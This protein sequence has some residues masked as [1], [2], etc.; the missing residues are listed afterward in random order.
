M[1]VS[2]LVVSNGALLLIIY[3]IPIIVIAPSVL[4]QACIT[5]VYSVK[6]GTLRITPVISEAVSYNDISRICQFH[7]YQ[8]TIYERGLKVVVNP[9]KYLHQAW[10]QHPFDQSNILGSA[11]LDITGKKLFDTF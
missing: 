5:Y 10:S 3:V 4:F 8:F 6:E 1:L 9:Y 2:S 11:P 7:Y